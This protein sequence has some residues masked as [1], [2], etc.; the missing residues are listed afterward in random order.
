MNKTL[1][2]EVIPQKDSHVESILQPIFKTGK[3][4]RSDQ[5]KLLSLTLSNPQLLPQEMQRI[6]QVILSLQ[7]GKL[8][9]VD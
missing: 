7:S 5:Q 3:I 9:V 4:T 1:Y 6:N 2:P 8:K